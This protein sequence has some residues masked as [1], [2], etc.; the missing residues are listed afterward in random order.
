MAEGAWSALGGDC[1]PG[2]VEGAVDG[3]GVMAAPGRVWAVASEK[4]ARLR[5]AALAQTNRVLGVMAWA[6]L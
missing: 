2:A 5:A 4:P 1:G 3:G 6:F